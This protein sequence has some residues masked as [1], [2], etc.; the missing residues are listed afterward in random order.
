MGND[1][2]GKLLLAGSV[3]HDHDVAA[4]F[5]CA[6]NVDTTNSVAV[7]VVPLVVN[8]VPAEPELL[9]VTSLVNCPTNSSSQYETVVLP[10]IVTV[11]VSDVRSAA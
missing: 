4:P 3:V 1:P 11:I 8:V 2:V 5:F 9:P 7:V 10:L 6:V